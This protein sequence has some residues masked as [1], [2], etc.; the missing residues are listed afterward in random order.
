MMNGYCYLVMVEPST[1]KYKYYEMKDN[2]NGLERKNCV[3]AKKGRSLYRD[4]IVFY[5]ED[6]MVLKYLVIFDA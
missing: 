5:T 1:N 4:E 2:G 6:A 3:H